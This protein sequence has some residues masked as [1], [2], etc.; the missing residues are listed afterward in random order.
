M[1][2]GKWPM[3]ETEG[4]EKQVVRALPRFY[5]TDELSG[6]PGVRTLVGE[7]KI[8]VGLRFSRRERREVGRLS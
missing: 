4:L 2:N 6:D 3:Q 7:T 1:E 5:N 8:A